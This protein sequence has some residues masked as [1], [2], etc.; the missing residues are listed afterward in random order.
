MNNL[1]QT[2]YLPV[3]NDHNDVDWQQILGYNT[4]EEEDSQNPEDGEPT[5]GKEPNGKQPPNAVPKSQLEIL[6]GYLDKCK[7]FRNRFKVAYVVFDVNGHNE[8]WELESEMFERWLAN[9]YH[10]EENKLPNPRIIRQAI[11]GAKS[12]AM[13]KGAEVN[14]NLRIAGDVNT[15]YYDL[16]NPEWQ[17][18]E[19]TPGRWGIKPHLPAQFQ[20]FINTAPQMVTK[21]SIQ[22]L[23]KLDA[24]INSIPAESERR[25]IKI[26][27]ITCLVPDIS[28]PLLYFSGEKGGGKSTLCRVTKRLVDPAGEDLLAFP[29]IRRDMIM[30]LV[31]NHAVAFDNVSYLSGEDSNLLCQTVTGTGVSVRKLFTN[32]TEVIESFRNCV[33]INGINPAATKSDLQDRMLLI[34]VDRISDRSRK[35]ENEFWRAFEVDRPHIF[36][37]MLEILSEAMRIY[38]DVQ[39]EELPRLTGFATWGYAIAEA[40]GIGGNQFLQDLRENMGLINQDTLGGN[41]IA[42]TLT[43]FMSDKESWVGTPTKLFSD[44]KPVATKLGISRH[45]SFPELP[46]QLTRGLNDIKSNL[47][48][49]GIEYTNEPCTSGVNRGSKIIKL[50]KSTVN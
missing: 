22:D 8:T 33:M 35:E 7:F 13:Y 18:V 39:L 11:D 23:S 28:H 16:C 2:G 19:I 41:P 5:G 40:A 1:F 21:A 36:G 26:Y 47:L 10:E 3:D 6:T 45:K 46:N 48:A 17:C 50:K 49:A 38:P 9:K 25:L 34:R 4:R 43:T 30:T 37:S 31:K 14:P 32:S 15:I 42:Y 27:G 29:R 12:I 24:Y 44:L 20:R